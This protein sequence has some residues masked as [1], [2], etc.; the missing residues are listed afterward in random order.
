M[1]LQHLE[2]SNVHRHQLATVAWHAQ[3]LGV[4]QHAAAWLE[5]QLTAVLI[6]IRLLPLP[7][8]LQGSLGTACGVLHT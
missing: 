4:Q 6:C 7:G 1:A 2:W 5:Q 3:V 8:R